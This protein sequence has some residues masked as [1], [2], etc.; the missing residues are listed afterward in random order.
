MGSVAELFSPLWL[1]FGGSLCYYFEGMWMLKLRVDDVSHATAIHLLPGMWGVIST[2]LFAKTPYIENAYY[3]RAYD[4][5]GFF[6]SGEKRQIYAQLAMLGIVIAWVGSLATVTY[7]VGDKLVGSR[8]DS[9][10]EKEGV[11]YHIMGGTQIF[12]STSVEPKIK[13]Q[14]SDVILNKHNKEASKLLRGIQV[15]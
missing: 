1:G 8:Y 2:G 14:V 10:W 15:V 6:I 5:S 4:C 9:F 3:P 12:T 13:G 11:D 7:I